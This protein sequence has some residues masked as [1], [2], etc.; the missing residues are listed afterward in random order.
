MHA[1]LDRSDVSEPCDLVWQTELP[2]LPPP[3]RGKVR[4]IYDLGDSLLIIA[5]DRISAYDHVLHPGI[6]GKG[7]ILNQLSNHW[8]ARLADLVPHHLLATEVAD[9][10]TELRVHQAILRHRSV[11]VRKA[12]V[13]PFEC[14]ARGYLAGSALREY[15]R[16]G[17]ACGFALAPGLER[18]SRLPEPIFTPATKAENGHDENIDFATLEAALG[19]SLA[20]RLR[21]LTLAIYRRSAAEALEH[22]LILADTKLEFGLV[23]GEL[24]LID[25][26]LTPD[27]SR[28]WQADAWHPGREPVS[29]DKQYVRDWLDR[30]GWDHAATPPRLP[31][32]VVSGTIARYREIFERLV[33]HPPEL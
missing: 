28:Y 2:G 26:V 20:G 11:K 23:A 27:S 12:D 22:G 24:V 3:R 31:A 21:D 6:A 4:D 15:V 8:F 19:A 30:E 5:C 18:A 1:R 32:T 29:F 7:K 14:V 25:E 33:G 10:P 9:F 17:V 16:T 13:V